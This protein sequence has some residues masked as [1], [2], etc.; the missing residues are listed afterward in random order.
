MSKEK[1]DGGG[2]WKLKLYQ[3]NCIWDTSC[4]ICHG[5]CMTSVNMCVLVKCETGAIKRTI[6]SFLQ[7]LAAK[8]YKSSYTTECLTFTQ[9]KSNVSLSHWLSV[10]RENMDVKESWYAVKQKKGVNE[11]I[12][13]KIKLV[14][15]SAWRECWEDSE[16]KDRT[17]RRSRCMRW[18]NRAFGKQAGMSRRW[19]MKGKIA[20][21]FGT[22][23][24]KNWPLV[25]L[26]LHTTTTEGGAGSL[27]PS[28]QHFT[29]I[30]SD[31]TPTDQMTKAFI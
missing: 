27:H 26:A 5:T 1:A 21:H 16:H 23:D 8:E 17:Q 6:N 18:K 20:K 28:A 10:R 12:R 11:V 4:I 2:C 7:F 19:R 31:W 3:I 24:W 25:H 13:L 30:R 29:A 15:K 14:H 22:D 9:G